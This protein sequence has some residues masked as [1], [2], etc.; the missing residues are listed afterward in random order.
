MQIVFF[1]ISEFE[2][3][4]FFYVQRNFSK[5]TNYPLEQSENTDFMLL[6]RFLVVSSELEQAEEYSEVAVFI[7][8]TLEE[9]EVCITEG[10]V[11]G[12]KVCI[13]RR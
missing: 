6:K 10:R 11:I 2:F 3:S 1:L 7:S 12:S 13:Y 9:T 8:R 5:L 4:I